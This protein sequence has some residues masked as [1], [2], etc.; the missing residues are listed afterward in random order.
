MSDRFAI[1]ID[2]GGTRIKGASFDLES[3][4]MLA[5]DTRLTDDGRTV[6]E[7]PAWA[8][9]VRDLVE[10]LEKLLPNPG[11]AVG[12]AAPGLADPEGAF[13][14]FMPGRLHGLQNFSWSEFLEREDVPVLNDAHA[15]LMGEIWQGAAKGKKDVILLTIGTG[16]GGAIVSG[17]RLLHGHLGRAGHLG[18]LTIDYKGK[19]DICNCPGS[20]ENAIG[21]YTIR[22]R[23]EGRFSSTRDV[24]DAIETGDAEAG[25]VWSE[26]IR[27]LGAAIASLVNVLD[28]EVV[29][30]GGGISEADHLLFDPL[31]EALDEFEWRPD[32]QKVTIRKAELGE[33]A[34]T[35][36]AA[37]NAIQE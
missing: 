25:R 14:R 22:E 16:V 29:L 36:G 32:N 2:L 19:P 6:G 27:A 8:V 15:A 24:L 17:G 7:T 26:S 33:W 31:Q 12:I 30:I 18:H 1:G 23:S 4:E 20:I 11:A 13:I 9:G 3:G 34:G 5:M 10:A 37:W 35:Y 28:P 21:N